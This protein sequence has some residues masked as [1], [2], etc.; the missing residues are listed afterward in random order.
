MSDFMNPKEDQPNEGV[1]PLQGVLKRLLGRKNASGV[2]LPKIRNRISRI[3]KNSDLIR[4]NRQMLPGYSRREQYKTFGIKL[5]E[6]QTQ[7]VKAGKKSVSNNQSSRWDQLD[8]SLSNGVQTESAR[9]NI[10]RPETADFGIPA[11]GQVIPPFSPPAASDGPSFMERRRERLKNQEA[12]KS[13]PVANKQDKQT[14]LFSRVEEILPSSLDKRAEASQTSQK[15]VVE[16]KAQP[17][18]KNTSLPQKSAPPP[19]TPQEKVKFSEKEI[20]PKDQPTAQ[21]TEPTRRES[22]EKTSIEK[23]PGSIAEKNVVQRQLDNESD[24]RIGPA[25]KKSIPEHFPGLDNRKVDASKSKI[26]HLDDELNTLASKPSIPPINDGDQKKTDDTFTI[27]EKIK[28][29][30]KSSDIHH[31]KKDVKQ[32]LKNSPQKSSI[33]VRKGEK[34]VT[35]SETTDEKVKITSENEKQKKADT[36]VDKPAVASSPPNVVQREFDQDI[37]PDLTM[38]KMSKVDAKGQKLDLPLVYK[39]ASH[40]GDG[41]PLAEKAMTEKVTE[42]SAE[43][44]SG[45]EISSKI[46]TEQS[47]KELQKIRQEKPVFQ[48]K[49]SAEDVIQQS[50]QKKDAFPSSRQYIEKPQLKL[51]VPLI[52]KSDKK[53][54]SEQL[55]TPSAKNVIQR[56]AESK[57][58]KL[59]EIGGSPLSGDSSGEKLRPVVQPSQTS[60]Q[61]ENPEWKKLSDQK[62]VV[63]KTSSSQLKLQQTPLSKKVTQKFL[64]KDNVFTRTRKIQAMP[65]DSLPIMMRTVEKAK[66]QPPVK[67]PPGETTQASIEFERKKSVISIK[68]IPQARKKIQKELPADKLLVTQLGRKA[69][70]NSLQTDI[71]GDVAKVN[72]AARGINISASKIRPGNLNSQ[73]PGYVKAGKTSKFQRRSEEEKTVKN[74]PKTLSVSETKKVTQKFEKEYHAPKEEL[75]V[76]QMKKTTSPEPMFHPE[77]VVQGPVVQRAIEPDQ[78]SIQ[79]AD[80]PNAV[81]LDLSKLARDVYPIIKR[82]MAVEKER[83]SGRL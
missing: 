77:M 48:A 25:E 78:E 71:A 32:E 42:K 12:I 16:E 61:T 31:G 28:T 20:I 3:R 22:K 8:M 40:D 74:S 6:K 43:T 34:H 36:S 79:P 10:F 76:V 24:K 49:K 15:F 46:K 82:W 7:A 17:G 37:K 54:V 60:K 58:D 57:A 47:G 75:P 33:S 72:M 30:S 62:P 45:K 21:E 35:S 19:Q 50:R 66:T 23:L 39:K 73:T 69:I 51:I 5:L 26:N 55:I 53:S 59:P 81:K 64:H 80:D 2:A 4:K 29:P 11:G 14:R 56:Q 83:S 9:T 68:P 44:E 70:Q 1:S 38:K 27:V 65:K 13:K 52:K 18:A 41:V 63:S 67:L